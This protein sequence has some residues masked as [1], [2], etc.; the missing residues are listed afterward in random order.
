[1]ITIIPSIRNI[2]PEYIRP[3]LDKGLT[4]VVDDTDDER[5]VAN[6][7]E[8][9]VL[10][11]S[12]KRRLLGDLEICIPKKNGACRD[13]GL[14]A[15]YHIG[16]ENETVVCLDDDCE[17]F[18]NYSVE[19][20]QS[21]GRRTLPQVKT[22]HRFY[23]PLDLYILDEEI[24]PR[25]F[26]YEERGRVKDYNYQTEMDTNV[27]FNLGLWQGV[28]DINAIDKLYLK[29]FSFGDVSLKHKQV[30]VQKGPL[31][32]L[33][34]MNMIMN[35]KVIPAIYQLPMNVPINPN[36]RI[37]RY[38]DIWGGYICK[39]LIDIKGDALSIGEP[40]IYHHKDSDLHRNIVQ[41]HYC[42]I[43]NLQFCDLI[44]AVCE[45]VKPDDYLTMYEQFVENLKKLEKHYP[46]A[47]KDYLIPTCDKMARWTQ[48]LRL[49]NFALA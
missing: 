3:L 33:C 36:W 14:L 47:L 26:P 48:A 22:S 16:G 9:I 43:T 6:S 39:K 46:P 37:D 13:L 32:S 44:D 30:V 40:L 25:G 4:I 34:S 10:H 38:G 42:H 8:I 29:Q 17:V 7:K 35:R 12:D 45:N 49:R 11:Y 15:A 24:F 18:G 41:E 2:N 21:L 27:V 5:I 1:V 31:V 28:F 19:A 23:N 20:E